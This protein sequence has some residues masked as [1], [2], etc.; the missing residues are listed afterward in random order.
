MLTVRP[1]KIFCDMSAKSERFPNSKKKKKNPQNWLVWN[2]EREREREKKN[3]H[4]TSTDY[5]DFT[6]S[7]RDTNQELW[8]PVHSPRDENIFFLEYYAPCVCY[9]IDFLCLKCYN[10]HFTVF[11]CQENAFYP[12][13]TSSIFMHQNFVQL[14]KVYWK[15]FIHRYLIYQ[16]IW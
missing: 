7:A 13:R 10:D 11:S 1:M 5:L 14:Q 15:I 3:Q 2:D 8:R 16:D 12:N 4:I 6:I 9:L